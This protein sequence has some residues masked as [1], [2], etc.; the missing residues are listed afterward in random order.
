MGLRALRPMAGPWRP[1]QQLGA[2][3]PGLNGA[4]GLPPSSKTLPAVPPWGERPGYT[5][6]SKSLSPLCLGRGTTKSFIG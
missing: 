4:I 3:A 2:E 1:G 6:P 5:S